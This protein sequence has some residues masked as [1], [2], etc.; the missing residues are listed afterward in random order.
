MLDNGNMY[1]ADKPKIFFWGY[2]SNSALS[3]VKEDL[4]SLS[5]ISPKMAQTVRTII[6]DVMHDAIWVQKEYNM[7]VVINNLHK[8]V[9]ASYKKGEKVVLFGHSAGSFVTYR[10]LFH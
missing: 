7:Q 6:A 9:M 2:N 5:M 8:D 3:T 4:L 10:Y 1:V